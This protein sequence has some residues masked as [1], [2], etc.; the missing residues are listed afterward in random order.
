MADANRL[1][2]PATCDR[3]RGTPG[4]ANLLIRRTGDQFVIDPHAMNS[5]T[6]TLG[7]QEIRRLIAWL[8]DRLSTP[9]ADQPMP[10]PRRGDQPT[11]Q[12]QSATGHR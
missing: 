5:C 7:S 2:L 8:T 12:T 9:P 4:F 11:R 10:A 6:F 3:H 1:V